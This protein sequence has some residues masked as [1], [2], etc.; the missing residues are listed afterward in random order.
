MKRRKGLRYSLLGV[1]LTLAGLGF[2][3]PQTMAAAPDAIKIGSVIALTG[4]MAAGGKDVKAGYELAVKDINDAGGV[5]V[6]EFG[7]KLPLELLVVDDES[8]PVKTTTRLDKL[9]SVDKV[10]AYLGG[11]SSDLNVVGMAAAEK[12]NVPWIGVTIAV[13]A[14]FNAGYKWVFAP[15]SMSHD[16]VKAFFDLLDSI[17]A[18]QRPRKIG[19]LELNVDWGKECAKYVRDMAKQRGYT[20]VVDQKY[21]PPTN[22]FSSAI[23]ALKSAG[24]EALFSVPTPPQSILMVKQMKEL[25]YA[26]KVTCLIRGPDLTTYWQAVGKDAN[27]IIS[28]GNWDESMPYPGN[29][30][31]VEEYRAKNPDAKNIGL[32]V[33]PAY[34]AVQILADAIERAGSL[35]RRK[36]RDAIAKTDMVTVRGPI[37]FRANGTAIIDYGLRQWQNGKNVLIWPPSATKNRVMLAIPWDKRQ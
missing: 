23:L 35:D 13:E 18:N 32:P 20:I 14:P 37:K 4:R 22:D 30:R 21:A 34:A 15:F 5:M 26:P 12:N 33:G 1:V 7:R 11:F 8:D 36:I 27:Y 9:N 2:V 3:T 19:H 25:N 16:Q 17:P 24:A 29:K 6:K 10:A 28:D 31:L